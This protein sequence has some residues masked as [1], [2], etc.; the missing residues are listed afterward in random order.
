M[1]TLKVKSILFSLM[2]TFLFAIV[3]QSCTQKELPLPTEEFNLEAT[4]LNIESTTI[5][6]SQDDPIIIALKASEDVKHY[7]TEAGELLW[8]MASMITYD[9]EETFPIIIVPIDSGEEGTLSTFVAA[10][11]E[12]K[13]AFHSFLNN[14]ELASLSLDGGYT[15]T[16]EYKTVDNTT[17]SK[18]I[19]EK[20]EVLQDTEFEVGELAY[21]GVD[22]NCFINCVKPYSFA[23]LASGLPYFCSSSLSCCVP[24]PAPA[25]PCCIGAAGCALYYGGVAGYCAY[26]CWR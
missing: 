6:L 19:F 10:Y 17:V 2:A 1:N 23:S 16:I 20:G 12:E 26:Q 21:R 8:D 24:A 7:N 22:V 11:N 5:E 25:N 15:G 13:G 9:N 14:F 18:T 3:I 4:A